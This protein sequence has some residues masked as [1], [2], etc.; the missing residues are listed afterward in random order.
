[1]INTPSLPEIIAAAVI[2]QQSRVLIGTT[3]DEDR[4]PYRL[5]EQQMLPGYKERLS[6]NAAWMG[7]F[8][9]LNAW[10]HYD[11]KPVFDVNSTLSFSTHYT[12]KDETGNFPEKPNTTLHVIAATHLKGRW[13]WL[14]KPP[15]GLKD[16]NWMDEKDALRMLDIPQREAVEAIFVQA[17]RRGMY[18]RPSA[19]IYSFPPNSSQQPIQL[20]AANQ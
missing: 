17:R 13:D 12:I 19:T 9:M 3:V 11:G 15:Y 20:S 1:M 7:V 10:E 14:Y 8:H 6:Q 5:L 16:L 2:D 4:I 18:Q